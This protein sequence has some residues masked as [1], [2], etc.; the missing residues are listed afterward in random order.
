MTERKKWKMKKIGI[1]TII[2]NNN[3]G[4]R[5]QNY[6]V[7]E[8]I[9]KYNFSAVTLKN[10]RW[11]NNK[12]KKIIEVLKYY[13][14][15]LKNMINQSKRRKILFKNFNSNI[16]FSDNMINIKNY[17]SIL[18]QYDF[19]L[20][21]SDQVWN[22]NGGEYRDFTDIQLLYGITDCKKIAF[23]FRIISTIYNM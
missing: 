10:S 1:V 23:S 16:L 21:G 22:P 19:L 14:R 5:L 17:I 18:E 9:K 12:H 8:K 15:N 6:A 3:Y 13:F 7:Q 4:N 11:K 20:V 2:D